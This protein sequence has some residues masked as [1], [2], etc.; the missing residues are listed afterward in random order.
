MQRHSRR[1]VFGRP[2]GQALNSLSYSGCVYPRFGS[3]TD[4]EVAVEQGR[5]RTAGVRLRCGP[6][7]SLTRSECGLT[8][9]LFR[10]PYRGL[11]WTAAWASRMADASGRSDWAGQVGT[12]SG[13]LQAGDDTDRCIAPVN[14]TKGTMSGTGIRPANCGDGGCCWRQAQIAVARASRSPQFAM[15]CAAQAITT[16]RNCIDWR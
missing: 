8:H 11:I 4:P 5:R 9:T 16:L 3:G 2:P 10:Q 12:R 14:T 13:S 15:L 7:T 1:Y 6:H